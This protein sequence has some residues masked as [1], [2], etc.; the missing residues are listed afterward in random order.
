M[1]DPGA[2]RGPNITE[3]LRNPD[4]FGVSGATSPDGVQTIELTTEPSVHGPHGAA[5]IRFV[6]TSEPTLTAEISWGNHGRAM[7]RSADSIRV[8]GAFSPDV[9]VSIRAP[10]QVRLIARSGAGAL[11][12]GPTVVSSALG[13]T[14][15]EW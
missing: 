10:G 8:W 6:A 14:A 11:L 13:V 4:A 2:L 5:R 9:D 15:F 12:A 7:C 1:S 3:R